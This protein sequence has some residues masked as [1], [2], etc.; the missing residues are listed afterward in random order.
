MLRGGVKPLTEVFI[1]PT[2][3]A[4]GR[5]LAVTQHAGMDSP[6]ADNSAMD[7]YAVAVAD[8]PA[9]GTRLPVS[10]TIA[11]GRVGTPLARG[12]A[13]RIFTGGVM[14]DGADA[15]VMQEHCQAGDGQVQIE[16]LPRHGE[17]VRRAGSDIAA[18]SEILVAG[19]RLRPQ[20]IALAASVGLADLPVFRRL[21]VAVFFTG[22]ELRMPGEPLPPGAIYNTNRFMLNALLQRLGCE[23]FDQGQVPDDLPSTRQA[24]R[25]AAENCDLII[26]SGGVSVGDEDHVKTAVTAEGRLELWKIAIKPGK[27]LAFGQIRR[28]ERQEV[29]FI[30]L[31]GNPVSGLVTFLA[32]VRPAILVM[33]GAAFTEPRPYLLRADFDWP[34]PDSRREFLRGRRNIDGG[35]DLFTDQGAS[36]LRSAVWSDG[37]IDNPPRQAIQRGDLVRY[38]PFSELLD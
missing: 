24:L 36:I 17:H 32:L 19:Q 14:P 12:S 3:V 37:L 26:S 8:L 23:V 7:G 25:R 27:P 31:P 15:V 4:A 5:V 30:G 33:Q 22:D 10:Q 28:D 29:P 38:L 18:G 34:R 16:H 1:V 21:R 9:A 13:A 20:D 2:L 35:V 11:A 6:P